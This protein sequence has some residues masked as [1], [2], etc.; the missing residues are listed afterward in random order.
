MSQG[1]T[2]R[3][4]LV[5]LGVTTDTGA[6][7]A[8]NSQ[9]DKT[10]GIMWSAAGLAA[11]LAAA[12]TA[13]AAATWAAVG[14]TANH[15]EMLR[16]QSDALGITT[17]EMQ[18]LRHAFDQFP[19]GA[20]GTLQVMNRINL[21]LAD[22]RAGSQTARDGWRG[23]G[24]AAED[25]KGLGL[26]AVLEGLAEGFATTGD[27]QARLAALNRIFG[28][29]LAAKV[30]P[31]LEQGAAGL[32]GL[33]QQARE[34]SLVLDSDTLES[35]NRVKGQMQAVR[36][37]VTN[38]AYRMGAALAP[39]IDV[40]TESFLRWYEAN[41]DWIQ[42]RFDDAAKTVQGVFDRVGRA[43]DDADRWIRDTLGGWERAFSAAGKALLAV[44]IPA[45]LA[46]ITI[47]AVA[48][49]TAIAPVIL[50]LG[51]PFIATAAIVGVL[52]AA[53]AVL[54]VVGEDLYQW[55]SGGDSVFGRYLTWLGINDEALRSVRA[56]LDAVKGV[57]L[58]FIAMIE[59]G[60]APL[61]G[62][63]GALRT[64][65]DTL[66]WVWKSFWAFFGK[67]VM[68]R[69]IDAMTA[70]LT[71]L[72]EVLSAIAKWMEAIPTLA[73]RWSDVGAKL[74]AAVGFGA[75]RVAGALPDAAVQGAR[76]ISDQMLAGPRAVMRAG[77]TITVGDVPVYVTSPGATGEEIGRAVR[78]ALGNSIKLAGYGVGGTE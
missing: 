48:A 58:A 52:A 53:L 42:L 50:G 72:E 76:I 77:D 44:G 60:L 13:A 22:L 16:Q 51:A 2:I 24:L 71:R 46:A 40:A 74:R 31:A 10:K 30:A 56:A 61:G 59:G 34:L 66:G 55:M 70:G 6:I 5:R 38:L 49:G 18:E 9:L 23:L 14:A 21:S 1:R 73:G 62:M 35:L 78:T 37:V 28:D 39:S 25:F 11:G 69:G 12:I 57:G 45:I 19:V 32:Q 54:L 63:S 7:E 36:G 15:A 67:N 41:S 29:D 75:D 26:P 68:I 47:A 8:F 43:F 20:E 33:R 64:V 27:K 65:A 4:L 3:S 17:D